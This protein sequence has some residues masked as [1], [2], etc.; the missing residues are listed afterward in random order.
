MAIIRHNTKLINGTACCIKTHKSCSYS[1]KYYHQSF[2]NTDL[3]Y[4]FMCRLKV[5]NI[6]G[7]TLRSKLCIEAE[8]KEQEK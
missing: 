8:I 2:G 7:E 1:C 4:N 6:T 3:C 5:D